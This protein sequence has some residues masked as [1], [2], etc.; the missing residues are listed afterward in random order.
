VL[1]EDIV[2]ERGELQK[3]LDLVKKHSSISLK[4]EIQPQGHRE[5][6][7][8]S[9]AFALVDANE[10]LGKAKRDA[11]MSLLSTSTQKERATISLVG[12]A[13]AECIGG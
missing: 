9:G 2:G 12:A 8:E 11:S 3:E 13:E 1:R 4:R 6:V 5:C 7:Q 10:A